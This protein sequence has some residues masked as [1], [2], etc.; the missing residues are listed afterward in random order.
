MSEKKSQKE[1]MGNRMNIHALYRSNPGFD[2]CFGVCIGIEGSV[3]PLNAQAVV[4]SL[5]LFWN[6][7]N[8][9]AFQNNNTV[10][11]SIGVFAFEVLED[12]IF[13]IKEAET[14]LP[15]LKET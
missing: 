14:T 11:L 15:I 12:C 7:L 13:F 5:F 8:S 4:L 1:Q 10:G 9:A 2:L 3:W 6:S